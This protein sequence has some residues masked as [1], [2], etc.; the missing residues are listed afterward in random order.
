MRNPGETPPAFAGAFAPSPAGDRR[1]GGNRTLHW[2]FGSLALLLILLILITPT[3]ETGG[4]SLPAPALTQGV[5]RIDVLNGSTVLLYAESLGGV[6]YQSISIALN[7]TPVGSPG[8]PGTVPPHWN[9]YWNVSQRLVLTAVV[10]NLSFFLVNV[11]MVYATP[12]SSGGLLETLSW[13]MFEFTL[14]PTFS[15]TLLTVYPLAPLR[16]PVVLPIASPTSWA[17]S[18]LPQSVALAQG[19]TVPEGSG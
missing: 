13:G 14:T 17:L 4:F 5:L 2:A 11:S 3:L 19:P 6:R 18:S 7:E 15:P 12:S 10:T 9:V 8:R 16:G 1:R